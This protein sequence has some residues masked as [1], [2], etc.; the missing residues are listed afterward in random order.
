[1]LNWL[2]ELLTRDV[3]KQAIDLMSESPVFEDHPATEECSTASA[4][5]RCYIN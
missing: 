1:M 5:A 3:S 2:L 4:A